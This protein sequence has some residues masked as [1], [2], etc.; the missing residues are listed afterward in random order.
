M[1]VFILGIVFGFL[2]LYVFWLWFYWKDGITGAFLYNQVLLNWPWICGIPLAIATF[3][4]GLTFAKYH[5]AKVDDE[6]EQQ[7]ATRLKAVEKKELEAD[8][9][10][11]AARAEAK[12]MLQQAQD[13]AEKDKKVIKLLAQSRDKW[14]EIAEK[15]K[16]KGLAKLPPPARKR[17]EKLIKKKFKG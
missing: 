2:G 7:E 9:M 11:A 15:K 17:A 12:K 6:I 1:G 10:L 8:N 14:K 4:G 16:I 13:E 5:F 3:L